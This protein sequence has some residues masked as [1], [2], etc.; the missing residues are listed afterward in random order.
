MGKVTGY[1]AYDQSDS[2]AGLKDLFYIVKN[3][4]SYA[5]PIY[6][7]DPAVSGRKITVEQFLDEQLVPRT[8]QVEFSAA[9]VKNMASTPV[10]VIPAPG[11]NKI[12]GVV[13][14]WATHKF[15]SIGFNGV[16]GTVE[17]ITNGGSLPLFI[18][19][20]NVMNQPSTTS[21][22]MYHV[23]GDD[24]EVLSNAAI[25]ART[26]NNSTTG[27]GTLIITIT[28]FIFDIS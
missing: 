11:I 17:V 4:G 24:S 22:K 25:M 23:E 21:R 26:P 18:T 13:D 7:G 5:S 19:T 15:G 28:Y 20:G 2:N 27:D 9:E 14:V 3:T 6:D 12:V 1:T 8:I 16:G 10:E